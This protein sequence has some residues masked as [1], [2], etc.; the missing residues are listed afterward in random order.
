RI[1][2]AGGEAT[3]W[4]EWS[5]GMG[6][7]TASS[8]VP[9]LIAFVSAVPGTRE[10][11]KNPNMTV[12]SNI[13]YKADGVP[14]FIDPR[15]KHIFT[16]DLK[17]KEYKQVTEGKFSEGAPAFSPDGKWIA[18]AS[19]R[20]ENDDINLI[21][22]IW[23]V[24]VEGGTVEQLTFNEGMATAPGY[25]PDGKWIAYLG[26]EQGQGKT[27]I[28]TSLLIRPAEGGASKDL[29]RPHDIS[30][31][32]AVGGACRADPG[33]KPYFWSEDSLSLLTVV[34]IRGESNIHAV[35][36]D[37]ALTPI[38]TGT[39]SITS[40]LPVKGNIAYIV[41]CFWCGSDIYYYDGENQSSNRLTQLNQ[42]LLQGIALSDPEPFE[43]TSFD[44]A[45]VH[46][47][48][49]KPINFNPAQK[50]PMV[51]QIHGG[52]YG[53]YGYSLALEFQLMASQ[54]MAVIYGN[55]RGSAGYGEQHSLG[56]VGDWGGGDYQDLMAL[57]DH[58]L[59]NNPWIDPARLGVTGTSY[60][61]FMTNWMIGHTE[62]F[63]AAVTINSISNMYTKYGVSDIGWTGNRAGYGGRD[64]WD[65]EDYIMEHSPIRY[66]PKVKTPTLIIHCED[67]HR[68]P[69]EQAE[70]WFVAL[71]RLGVTTEFV[72]FAG[73]SHTFSNIG[74]PQNRLDRLRQI[75]R[76]FGEHLG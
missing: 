46:G 47:W 13:R 3:L 57:V 2:L 18:F 67:D 26:H 45:K 28:N 17:T 40:F 75:M 22:N 1:A 30:L 27:G 35:G 31:G 64:L 39:H 41:D 38:T 29:T 24:P 49:M 72:R 69:M 71:K 25:S 20:L 5:E 53:V 74:K 55:P 76:W 58:T 37:G 68:C 4:F 51:L 12:I 61:G 15:P 62:R 73:E 23:R 52:P 19:S 8:A 9:G 70:Q 6:E 48:L 44:G 65:S 7:I 10:E 56:V 50:Y 33:T 42:E 54:G 59:A 66:A 36:I 11:P 16:L 63:A 34:P 43:A 14:R 60:G 32:A 21:Q